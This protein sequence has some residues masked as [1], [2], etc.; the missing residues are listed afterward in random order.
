MK[1]AIHR[2]GLILA[3][4]LIFHVCCILPAAAAPIVQREVAPS[5]G[6]VTVTYTIDAE[7][8]FAIGIVES[9]PE[10][11]TFAETDNAISAAPHFEIDRD[12]RKIAFFVCDEKE[13]SY[14][15]TGTGDGIQGF[16][17][18]WVDLCELSPDLKEGKGRWNTLGASSVSSVNLQQETQAQKSPGFGICAALLGCALGAGAIAL[19]QRTGGDEA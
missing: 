19:R 9:V 5:G 11:W 16:V 14:T 3:A 13:V 8:P 17:T 2:T 6:A 10:G 7:E 15:L 4:L 12:G 18:E 1:T